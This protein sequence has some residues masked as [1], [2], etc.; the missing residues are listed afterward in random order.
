MEGDMMQKATIALAA[1]TAMAWLGIHSAISADNEDQEL[2][3]ALSGAKVTL[4]Q[5]MSSAERN[6]RPISAKFEMEDGKLQLSV[7]TEKDGKFFEVIV[8]H[9]TALI[10][11]TE[12]ITEGDDLKEAKEQNAA[13]AKSKGSLSTAVDKAA[14]SDRAVAV[15]PELKGGRPVASVVLVRGGKLQTVSQPIE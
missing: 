7:Y 12:P 3:K 1:V 9:A 6:G 15:T 2:I 11:K 8:D 5:A 14:G 4:Q 13:M 10:G